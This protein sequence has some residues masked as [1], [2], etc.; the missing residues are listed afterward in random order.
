VQLIDSSCAFSKAA[1]TVSRRQEMMQMQLDQGPPKKRHASR[2]VLDGDEHVDHIEETYEEEQVVDDVDPAVVVDAAEQAEQAD[3]PAADDP[4]VK[5]GRGRPRRTG[6]VTSKNDLQCA[7]CG[8]LF[9][10]SANAR[11][12]EMQGVCSKPASRDPHRIFLPGPAVREIRHRNGRGTPFHRRALEPEVVSHDELE[13]RRKVGL[14]CLFDMSHQLLLQLLGQTKPVTNQTKFNLRRKRDTI[15]QFVSW[16]FD[17]ESEG[18]TMEEM[19]RLLLSRNPIKVMELAERV[20][21]ELWC[22][23]Y[24]PYSGLAHGDL[25]RRTRDGGGRDRGRRPSATTHHPRA[26]DRSGRGP[27]RGIRMS[28]ANYVA[29]PCLLAAV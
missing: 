2:L 12:H 4:P 8:K 20:S 19:W 17:T 11:K 14:P 27:P 13:T 29:I 6:K 15:F 21:E 23:N 25:G 5:R 18:D 1:V 22:V 7:A 9:A 16:Q 26:D 10:T 24:A 28:T 3:V